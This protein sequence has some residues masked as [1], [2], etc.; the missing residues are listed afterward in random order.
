MSTGYSQRD[1]L[2]V[3][4]G[5]YPSSGAGFTSP[6]DLGEISER[7]VRID[8]FEILISAQALSA[9]NLPASNSLVYSLQ[10]SNVA[11][12]S[13]GVIEWSA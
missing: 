4:E 11:D 10:F 3:V 2:G 13:S 9:T 8:P 5:D 6:L 1:V 12:F 7:G